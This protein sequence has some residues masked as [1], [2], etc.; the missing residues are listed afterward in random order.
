[1]PGRERNVNQI[2]I[3]FHGESY[4]KKSGLRKWAFSNRDLR[5]HIFHLKSYTKVN[6]NFE[7]F[8]V[9]LIAKSFN[10]I[11]YLRGQH[12]LLIV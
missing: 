3:F 5:L 9:N 10:V 11:C 8:F 4:R 1:M 2:K 12:V 7:I 6:F